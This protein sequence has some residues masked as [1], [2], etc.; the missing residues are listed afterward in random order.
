MS[1]WAEDP[2]GAADA[3]ILRS[4]DDIAIDGRLLIVNQGGSLADR[5]KLRGLAFGLWNRRLVAGLPAFSWPP[6]GPFDLALARLPKARDE[7]A[8]T[9]HATLSVLVPAG[10]LILY[11]GNDEGIRS[12]AALLVALCG[13]VETMAAR[14]TAA[15]W[16]SGIRRIRT[17][18]AAR[19][20]PGGRCRVLGS[21]GR[22]AIG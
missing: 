14:A 3:L 17:N 12:G 5:L 4:L 15:C 13:G 21:P 9:L 6:S 2:E 16:Q 10:R 7:Q 20:P 22:P 11:G 18:C 1:R 19:W 8:M